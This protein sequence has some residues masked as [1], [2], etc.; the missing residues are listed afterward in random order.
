MAFDIVKSGI[1]TRLNA[2]GYTESS[3]AVD[4][5]QAPAGEYGNT[6]IIKSLAGENKEG[7]IV[8]RFYDEQ[9]WQVLIA[10]ER[11][12]QNDI[13]QLDE[14]H[15]AKD[16]LIKDIDKP[17]NWTGVAQLLKYK[18]WQVIEFPNYFVLDTRIL[19]LDQFIY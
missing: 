15:R 3:Q 16:A 18:S 4:F 13:V 8:D 2:L 11:S 5:K 14:L 19:I 9:E 12:S 6:Y 7:T 17:A 10:F 1:A